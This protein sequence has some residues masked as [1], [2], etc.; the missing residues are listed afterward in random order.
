LI[1][2]PAGASR[3]IADLTTM[4]AALPIGSKSETDGH[5]KAN[6]VYYAKC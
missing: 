4:F 1:A 5:C 3:A 6:L 2:R